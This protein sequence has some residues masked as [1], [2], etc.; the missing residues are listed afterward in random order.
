MHNTNS[1]TWQC[2]WR[3]CCARG[4]AAIFRVTCTIDI[5]RLEESTCSSILYDTC[6]IRCTTVHRSMDRACDFVPAI[7]H[8]RC[9][10]MDLIM[11]P[12]R[13]SGRYIYTNSTV[14]YGFY[15]SSVIHILKSNKVV[16]TL[17]VENNYQY[18]FLRMVLISL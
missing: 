6:G 2:A 11:Q 7:M 17:Q 10:F 15:L 16:K 13:F 1:H 4:C 14:Q 12:N 18:F 8:T 9:F 5:G 3:H